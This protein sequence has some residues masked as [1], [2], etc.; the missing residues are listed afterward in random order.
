MALISRATLP[1]EFFDRTSAMMLVQPEPQYL[2]AQLV[3]MA[4]LQAELRANPDAFELIAGRGVSGG[5]GAIVKP[6][7]ENQL[8]LVAADRI[9]SEAIAVSS[10]LAAGNVAHTIRMNRPVFSGGGFTAAARLIASGQAISTVG[11]NISNEQVEITIQRFAGPYDVANS[12]VAP[13]P[14]DRFDA[15]RSVHDL[16]A[17]VGVQLQRDRM[18]FVDSVYGAIFDSPSSSGLVFPGDPTNSLTSDS[19]AFTTR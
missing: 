2:Y 15:Q 16:V 18:K 19:S 10:E 14:I 5:N 11:T 13:Y 17:L 7:V 12:R 3:F 8:Q 4:D 1:S 9:H 6:Y